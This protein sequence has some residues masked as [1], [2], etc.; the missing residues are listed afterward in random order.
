MTTKTHTVPDNSQL[1][2]FI[3]TVRCPKCKAAQLYE[4]Y[5]DL[6]K[7]FRNCGHCDYMLHFDASNDWGNDFNKI[8]TP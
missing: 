5:P 1:E 7:Q 3:T 6:G 2:P 8:K 4:L